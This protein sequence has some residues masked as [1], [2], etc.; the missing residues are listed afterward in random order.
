MRSIKLFIICFFILLLNACSGN[1]IDLVKKHVLEYDKSITFGSALDNYPLFSKTTWREFK[2]EDGRRV[3]EFSADYDFQKS[4]EPVFLDF[5][6]NTASGT[7]THHVSLRGIGW[8][9]VAQYY[10]R[11]I[12]IKWLSKQLSHPGS[13]FHSA[14]LTLQ[15]VIDADQSGFEFAYGESRIGGESTQ[16][17]DMSDVILSTYNKSPIISIMAGVIPYF[18]DYVKNVLPL[19]REA[20]RKEQERIAIQEFLQNKHTFTGKYVRDDR[21]HIVVYNVKEI[22]DTDFVVDESILYFTTDYNGGRTLNESQVFITPDIKFSISRMKVRGNGFIIEHDDERPL[23][24][25]KRQQRYLI[26]YAGSAV[27]PIGDLSKED[28]ESIRSAAGKHA[29][30]FE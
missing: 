13:E 16:I 8:G 4:V 20:A 22:S 27:R 6:K 30:L 10:Q 25:S 12:F 21:T 11:D 1:N 17:R 2:T 14:S 26:E 5:F 9:V 18:E 7:M 28:V 3:V 15:F 29:Y 24:I 23:V 19:E